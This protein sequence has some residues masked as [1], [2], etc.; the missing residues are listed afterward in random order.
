MDI[1]EQYLPK[2]E[3]EACRAAFE[4]LPMYTSKLLFKRG[5]SVFY[6]DIPASQYVDCNVQAHWEIF[7]KLWKGARAE[8][9]AIFAKLEAQDKFINNVRYELHRANPADL[10]AKLLNLFLEKP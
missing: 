2:A 5:G 3:Y 4:S 1:E 7:R 6:E 10:A 9:I 8:V